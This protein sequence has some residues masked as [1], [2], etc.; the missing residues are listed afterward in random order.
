M[1]PRSNATLFLLLSWMFCQSAQANDTIVIDRYFDFVAA[2]NRCEWFYDKY[3]HWQASTLDDSALIWQA[4]DADFFNIQ[5][6]GRYWLRFSVY[7][8]D[9]I[10]L[11]L[12]LGPGSADV[13]RMQLYVVSSLNTDSS[14]VT[15]SDFPVSQRPLK[16]ADLCFRALFRPQQYYTCYIYLERAATPVQTT[17]ILYNP[18]AATHTHQGRIYLYHSGFTV[19]VAALYGIIAILILFFFPQT[20][21]VGYALYTLGGLGYLTASLGVGIEILWSEYPYF[22]AF[23]EEFFAMLLSIGL[24]IMSRVVLQTPIRYK[25]INKL[26]TLTIIIGILYTLVG[27]WRYAFPLLMMT[28]SSLIAAIALLLALIAITVLCFCNY[29]RYKEVESLWFFTVFGF[30]IIF[31]ITML[32]T[33]SGIIPRTQFIN[34]IM[35]HLVILVEA[36]LA[37]LFVVNRIKNQ[38]LAR[39]QRELALQLQRQRELERISHD[40]HDEVGST[41]SSIS[42]LGDATLQNSQPGVG[43]NRLATISMRAREVMDTMSDIVW[44]VNPKNDD[45]GS[46]MLR[47]RE[48]AVEVLEAED[49]ALYF[50]SD[51]TLENLQLPMEQRKDLYLIF[52]EAINNAAKYAQAQNVWIHFSKNQQAIQLEIRD[53]GVGFDINCSTSGNG[54]RNMQVRAKRL[55]GNFV[56]N[57]KIKEGTSLTLSFRVTS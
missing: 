31:A 44:S 48:F 30:V 51:S 14:I 56:I 2:T 34:G 18:L 32:L 36:T 38:L 50:T 3:R 20:L 45:F 49:I 55:G 4:H 41:L 28:Y 40:L 16:N 35:P 46:I 47:M 13:Y 12:H 53:D 19:G 17:L 6:Q 42:I 24:L 37:T 15:G 39:Q 22:G 54:L 7:N 57:S 8:Q 43:Q 25:Y 33:Q 52:K 11:Y 29:Y 21:H 5:D 23:S 9:S 10:P 26:L 27:G 1:K